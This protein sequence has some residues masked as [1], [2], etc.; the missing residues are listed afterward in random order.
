MVLVEYVVEDRRWRVS[1]DDLPGVDVAR[2]LLAS[3]SSAMVSPL[4]NVR[5]RGVVL[6]SDW[7]LGLPLM[8]LDAL[9][10]RP[11]AEETWSIE[12]YVWTVSGDLRPRLGTGRGRKLW[13]GDGSKRSVVGMES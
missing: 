1:R 3:S 4:G 8:A 10:S 5:I 13:R 12:V 9:V 6:F 7:K 2:D 11:L